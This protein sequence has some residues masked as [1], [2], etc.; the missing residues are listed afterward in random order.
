MGLDLASEWNIAQVQT[1]HA[2]DVEE[3]TFSTPVTLYLSPGSWLNDDTVTRTSAA[4][5]PASSA[6][7]LLQAK[8][9]YLTDFSF[10]DEIYGVQASLEYVG[11]VFGSRVLYL[12]GYQNLGIGGLQ[13]QLRLIPNLDY[14]V[15][16]RGGDHTTR[17]KGDD[18]VRPGGTGSLDLRLGLQTFNALDAGVSYQFLETVSGSGGYSDLF[19]THVTLWVIQNVGM[20]FQYSKGETPVATQPIDLITLGLEFKY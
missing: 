17:V 5:G 4:D 7:F 1:N 2:K 9:Y 18:W 6:L 10:Q 16:G 11:N 14:S 13:Y 19:T 15:T 8:P 3:L 12:G 20:T